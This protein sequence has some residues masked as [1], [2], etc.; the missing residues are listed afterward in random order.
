MARCE[1]LLI[2]QFDLGTFE[3]PLAARV[4][5]FRGSRSPERNPSLYLGVGRE[6]LP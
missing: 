4:A 6:S 3:W 5:H 2:F 1:R